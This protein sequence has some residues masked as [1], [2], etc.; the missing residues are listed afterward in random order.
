MLI[1][2]RDSKLFLRISRRDEEMKS[3][4]DD[5][6]EDLLMSLRI[7]AGVAKGNVSNGVPVNG[8][9]GIFVGR[10]KDE[11]LLLMVSLMVRILVMKTSEKVIHR[12]WFSALSSRGQR[13]E[14][15][16]LRLSIVVPSRCS[17]RAVC[18]STH[19]VT[20]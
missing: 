11:I 13:S 16:H 18:G 7:S 6:L 3:I 5:L 17:H 4:E 12:V 19:A 1:N 20:L 8:R 9:S 15:V 14:G 2:W 10:R